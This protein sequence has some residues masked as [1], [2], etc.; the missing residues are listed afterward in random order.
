MKSMPIS[1]FKAEALQVIE[2]IATT[3]D[4]LVITK[5][6]KPLAQV[7]PYQGPSVKPRPGKLSATLVFETDIVSPLE[8]GMWES[9]RR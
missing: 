1:K 6:G 2:D 7:I 9:N 8:S 3:R 4:S 5:R